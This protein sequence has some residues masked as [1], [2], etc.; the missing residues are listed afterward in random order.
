MEE[1]VVAEKLLEGVVKANLTTYRE[2]FTKTKGE[3]ATDPYWRSALTLFAGLN[4]K[5]KETFFA[6]LKQVSVDTVSNVVGAIDGCTD[7][8]IKEEIVL[9]DKRGKVIS[10]SLQDYFLEAV[11]RDR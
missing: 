9:T 4:Q 8:G 11:E 1:K 10:G 5:E 6:V 3:E 2:L 7:I